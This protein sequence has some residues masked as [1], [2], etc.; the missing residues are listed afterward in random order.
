[1]TAK[2]RKGGGDEAYELYATYGFPQDLV[3]L[4]APELD[5]GEVVNYTVYF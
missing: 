2:V 5:A 1:M 3:E 4:I